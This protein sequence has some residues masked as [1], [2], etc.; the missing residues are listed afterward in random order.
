[1]KSI[2]TLGI[3]IGM[4]LALISFVG[5]G[6][7]S[8]NNF[9]AGVEPA[10]W[11]GSLTGKK[12]SLVLGASSVFSCNNV[13]FSGETKKIKNTELTVS[14]EL[15]GCE[16]QVGAPNAWTMNGCKFSLRPGP[17][18]A[19]TGSMDI[20]GCT[21]PMSYSNGSCQSQIGN[22]SSLGKVEYENIV[23][24]GT[25]AV[26]MIAKLSGMVYTR[27][28]TEACSEGV[29]GTF[30]DGTY[31]GEWTVKGATLT[32]IPAAAEVESTAF[33]PTRFAAE[34]GPASI[35]SIGSGLGL[36][37][38]F[39]GNAGIYCN[40]GFSGT[41]S[42]VPT[43]AVT[44]TPSFNSCV[45]TQGPKEGTVENITIG[46]CS[47]QLTP[48]NGLNIIGVGCAASPIT[49][50][51][52][53]C[54]FTISSQSNLA[55]PFLSTSGSG[56]SRTVGMVGMAGPGGKNSATY[57]ATGASCLKPGTMSDG[58]PRA[59]GTLSAKTSG[60]AAQGFWLE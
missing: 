48:Y 6:V 30:K 21:K 20:V 37:F 32:G 56:T 52:P 36:V 51:I 39:P 38:S 10:K 13:A 42:T 40:Y 17:G 55:G 25:P 28:N 14:P 45:F 53:G 8:A 31:Q 35:S 41:V 27:T 49:I 2:K 19:L 46:G 26:K 9:K 29:S 1:M 58:S 24:G 5:A 22:Q 15:G 57:T 50:T 33:S 23:V 47:Y 59:N 34:E 18:P 12:H 11:S 54:V 16:H 60:G 4:A 44:V 43:E 3:A 7:A